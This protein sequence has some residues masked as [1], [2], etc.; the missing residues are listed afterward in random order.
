MILSVSLYYALFLFYSEVLKILK[1]HCHQ[2]TGLSLF[3][4]N[5]HQFFEPFL[6][7]RFQ[8][9]LH[10]K[11]TIRL[12]QTFLG[13]FVG[14]FSCIWEVDDFRRDTCKAKDIHLEGT[15]WI[16]G[17]YV[18]TSGEI[19]KGKKH[20]EKQTLGALTSA[21]MPYGRQGSQ[22]AALR[23]GVGSFL[24]SSRQYRQA[25]ATP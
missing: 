7:T 18:W 15:L 2:P 16:A 3:Q 22:S 20:N 8:T 25:L 12:P 10:Q 11:V 23:G 17:F 19:K 13:V 21:W 5:F 24:L 14:Q 4:T 1:A 9:I 6:M